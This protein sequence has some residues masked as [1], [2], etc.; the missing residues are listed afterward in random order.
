MDS[1]LPQAGTS[2]SAQGQRTG[3]R[4]RRGALPAEALAKAGSFSKRTLGQREN[5]D[6]LLV[7]VALFIF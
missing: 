2:L 6:F 5:K 1:R 7:Y 3:R 4:K